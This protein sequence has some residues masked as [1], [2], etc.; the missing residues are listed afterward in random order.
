MGFRKK[1][2][3]TKTIPRFTQKTLEIFVNNQIKGK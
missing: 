1:T 2:K 3:Q